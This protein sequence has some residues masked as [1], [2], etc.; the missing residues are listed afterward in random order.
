VAAHSKPTPICRIETANNMPDYMLV[1]IGPPDEHAIDDAAIATVM[2]TLSGHSQPTAIN[3]LRP[4]EALE[5]PLRFAATTAHA[6]ETLARLREALSDRPLDVNLLHDDGAP[7]RKKL[8][9]ADMDSTIIQQE[10]IDEIAAQAGIGPQVSLITERAMRGELDFE[11]ALTERVSLLAGLDEAVLQQVF[12]TRIRLTPGAQT[13]VRTMA[14]HGT[15]CALVSGGFTF[16]TSRVAHQAGF[17]ENRANRLIIS[18]G[19]L[20]GEVA[21]PILGRSAKLET[22]ESLAHS[23]ALDLAD[24]LAVGD[25]AN[26]L[27]MINAAGLGVAFHAKPIVAREADAT[28]TQ[29]DLTA[30]L[31]LQ[32]Y[33]FDDFVLTA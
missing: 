1:L 19:R 15:Y 5:L 25:G 12:D 22:L 24:C 21:R 16:F 29:G 11:A 17:H 4:G 18:D 2:H 32:G 13:L 30:L 33:P 10:C 6:D 23:H 26:D 7:R 9:L 27:A 28:I 8:L 14:A 31:Y 20:S 3:W